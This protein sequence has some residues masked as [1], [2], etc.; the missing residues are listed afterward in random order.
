MKS[1]S[2]IRFPRFTNVSVIS[3]RSTRSA[4]STRTSLLCRNTAGLVIPQAG[5][6]QGRPGRQG[7]GTGQGHGRGISS[8]I[9]AEVRAGMQKAAINRS[10]RM[11]HQVEWVLLWDVSQLLTCTPVLRFGVLPVIRP[12]Q[13]GLT[14]LGAFFPP[15]LQVPPLVHSHFQQPLV[16]THHRTLEALA[17]S[18]GRPSHRELN[19]GGCR[20]R[21][22]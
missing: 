6:T 21:G 22:A 14:G 3:Y 1:A 9:W 18:T 13:T 11:R 17:I 16:G 4:S 15:L 8:T 19:W 10:E 5:M 7:G 2:P 12:C 20:S